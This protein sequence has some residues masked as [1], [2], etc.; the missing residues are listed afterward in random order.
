MDGQH[1][2][3]RQSQKHGSIQLSV[4]RAN[5]CSGGR[6]SAGLPPRR[7]CLRDQP[8]HYRTCGRA[9]FSV[10]NAQTARPTGQ[11]ERRNVPKRCALPSGV[12]VRP[13]ADTGISPRRLNFGAP[14]LRHRA[15]ARNDPGGSQA[16]GEHRPSIVKVANGRGV[17]QFIACKGEARTGQCW[18]GRRGLDNDGI[19]AIEPAK[20]FGNAAFRSVPNVKTA[21]GAGSG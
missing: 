5:P 21:V 2:A 19:P 17:R 12:I 14:G 16:F 20:R 11:N 8:S 9:N 10:S 3:V 6:S 13:P 1:S 7:P 4:T 18:N 15:I